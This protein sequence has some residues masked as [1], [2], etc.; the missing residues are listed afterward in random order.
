MMRRGNAGQFRDRRRSSIRLAE[1]QKVRPMDQSSIARHLLGTWRGGAGG[2]EDG[3][4]GRRAGGG[5]RREQ[6]GV[7]IQA[8]GRTGQEVVLSQA[9]QAGGAAVQWGLLVCTVSHAVGG[10]Y[11]S[12]PLSSWVALPCWCP[13]RKHLRL[14]AAVIGDGHLLVG[15]RG[16]SCVCR[17]SLSSLQPIDCEL[18]EGVRE[19]PIHWQTGRV[20][21]VPGGEH[22]IIERVEQEE[23]EEGVAGADRARRRL[24]L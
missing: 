7:F 5:N 15:L 19:P 12:Q 9:A 6:G 10:A 23:R 13:Q 16:Q 24:S 2:G 11:S 8:G 17:R 14:A 18:L 1:V 22:V 3:I 20:H 4:G 21:A